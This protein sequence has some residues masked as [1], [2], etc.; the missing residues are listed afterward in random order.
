MPLPGLLAHEERQRTYTEEKVDERMGTPL[1]RGQGSRFW[2][3]RV[4][5]DPRPCRLLSVFMKG[6]PQCQGLLSRVGGAEPASAP[7]FPFSKDWDGGNVQYGRR[8]WAQLNK[9]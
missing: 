4:G 3:L 2:V 9:G 5:V 1:A 8:D 7:D 6:G